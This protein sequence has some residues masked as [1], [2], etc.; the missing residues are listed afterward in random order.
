[1]TQPSFSHTAERYIDLLGGGAQARRALL[2]CSAALRLD[3]EIAREAISLV[4]QSNGSTGRLLEEIKSLACVWRQWDGT[5]YLEEEVRSYLADQLEAEVDQPIRTRLRELLADHAGRR[6]QAFSPDGPLT[7]YKTRASKIDAAYQKV[8][9]PGR[10][11]E[12]S[13]DFG[14]V[15]S[16]SNGSAKAATCEAVASLSPELGRRLGRLPDEI[17]FLRGMSAYQRRNW[18]EAHRDFETVYGNGRPGEIYATAAHL[19][20]RLTRDPRIAESAFRDSLA[21]NS[22]PF[23]QAQAW[24]SLG[25]L[26]SQDRRRWAEAE[27]AYRKSLKF[28]HQPEHKAQVWHSLGLLRTRQRKLP[29]AEEAYGHS[30]DLRSDPTWRG[31]VRASWADALMKLGGS[32]AFDRVEAYALEAQRLEPNGLKMRGLTSRVLADLYERRGDREKAISVLKVLLE[33]NRALGHEKYQ[34]RIRERIARLQKGA[35]SNS[36]LRS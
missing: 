22:T 16:E 13:R 24:H 36:S 6:A 17:L 11:D 23:H 34:A 3:D 20:G 8:L 33:T 29:A 12:G 2:A 35:A 14:E 32:E 21:W 28:L 1:M 19:F 27:E 5:W 15:W 26:L 4:G 18:P 31:R 30:L 10:I 9:T 7:A 25:N